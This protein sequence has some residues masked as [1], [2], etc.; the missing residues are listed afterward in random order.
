MDYE[1]GDG[2]GQAELSGGLGPVYNVAGLKRSSSKASG[3]HC[4]ESTDWCFFCE[5][6]SETSAAGTDA[7]LYGSL[8]GT[9]KR[10]S[11]AKREPAHIARV[12]KAAYDQDVRQHVLGQREWKE[13]SILR[14]LLYSL[15]FTELFDST[16]ENMLKA[17]ITRQNHELVDLT[18]GSVVEENRKAFCHSI[19]TYLKWQNAHTG[20]TRSAK[21]AKFTPK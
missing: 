5:Y 14:H 7:D 21:R 4:S 18:T 8:F 1:D 11:E 6:E 15:H 19:E 16:V 12:V 10:M 9:V 20:N 3:M 2:E 13:A 17:L